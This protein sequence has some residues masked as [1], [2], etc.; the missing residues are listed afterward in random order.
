MSSQISKTEIPA[1]NQTSQHH[2]FNIEWLFVIALFF[3]G[4]NLRS[5]LLEV[6]PVLPFIQHDLGLNYTQTGLLNSLPMLVFGAMA[7]PVSFLSNRFGA[8]S[9]MT[10]AILGITVFAFARAFAPNLE[11]LFTATIFL[12]LCITIG[13]TTMPLFVHRWFP[14]RL[15]QVTAMYSTGLMVGEIL[16]AAITVPWL[17]TTFA[18]HQWRLTFVYWSIPVAIALAI[19]IITTRAEQ[20]LPKHSIHS[21][22][23]SVSKENNN[24]FPVKRAIQGGLLLGSGSAMFFLMSTWIP[25]YYH[26]LHRTDGFLA[27][28]VLTISQLIASLSLMALG[29]RVTG[30][31]LGFLLVG[32]MAFLASILWFIIPVDWAVI[33]IGVYGFSSSALFVMGLTFAPII[34]PPHLVTQVNGIILTIGYILAFLAPF[35]GGVI[36][37]MT[38]NPH[39]VFIPQVLAALLCVVTSVFMKDIL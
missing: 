8:R 23:N 14:H 25:E 12:S 22:V 39:M 10:V 27:L 18:T 2:R 34:A 31:R 30:K 24:T 15:G 17:Y 36:W 13:Q 38:H 37:D 16:G 29:E 6:P 4:F 26:H 33:L 20:Q 19:W 11:T 35:A 5:V 7:I 9:T 32:G 28:S 3:V 1:R 21:L